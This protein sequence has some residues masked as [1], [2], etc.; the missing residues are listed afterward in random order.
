MLKKSLPPASF[1]AD[2]PT[3]FAGRMN[4]DFPDYPA[5]QHPLLFI[6]KK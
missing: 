5:F 3:S 1:G 6:I 4:R 2:P